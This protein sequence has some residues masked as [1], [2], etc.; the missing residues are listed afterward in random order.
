MMAIPKAPML[1]KPIISGGEAPP[2]R[3]APGGGAEVGVGKAAEGLIM[4]VEAG[5]EGC[6]SVP[7]AIDGCRWSGR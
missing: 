4:V 2:E 7:K 6:A 1:A 5:G 3:N